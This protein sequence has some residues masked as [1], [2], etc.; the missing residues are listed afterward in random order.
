LFLS[1]QT[2]K[3]AS[4]PTPFIQV[5]DF[6]DLFPDPQTDN[7][8]DPD[9]GFEASRLRAILASAT[10]DVV[11]PRLWSLSSGMVSVEDQY[12][13]GHAYS[14]LQTK[15]QN[16]LANISTITDPFWAQLPSGSNTGTLQQFIPRINSTATWEE[17]PSL[18][19]PEDCNPSSDAFYLHYEYAVQHADLFQYTVEI[20]MPGNMSQ[21]PWKNQRSRQDITEELY[22]KMNFTG[23]TYGWSSYSG[24][25]PGVHST[26]L[27]LRT[28]T[29]YFELPNY[30]N[31]QVPGPLLDAIPS[32]GSAGELTARSLENDTTWGILNATDKLIPVGLKGPLLNIAMALFGEASFVDVQHTALAAYGDSGTFYSGCIG[33]A[34]LVSFLRTDLEES[35]LLPCVFVPYFNSLQ[36][37]YREGYDS[38]IQATVSMYFWL[39]SGP[40]AA[41][42]ER[43]E[44]AFASAAFLANDLLMTGDL[45]RGY[46]SIYTSY[47]MGADQQIPHISRAGIIVVSALL[48]LDL[49]CLLALALYS[50][51]IPRWTGTLDSFAML[52]IG[53]SM[54]EKL[55]L[56]ATYHP[57]RIRA[58]DETPG[59]IGNGSASDDGEVGTLC[60][61]GRRPLRRT[62]LYRTYGLEHLTRRRKKKKKGG[63]GA[64]YSSLEG[65]PDG[66]RVS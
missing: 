19:L 22:F 42:P 4:F 38:E 37:D 28:T 63:K 20:C 11:Q 27:T 25:L 46:G 40:D 60:L 5:S 57:E 16:T 43:V 61:G 3:H 14:P 49:A 58:L 12:N 45:Y 48:G 8:H 30:A 32:S 55:P 9:H 64:G 54:S 1:F 65:P 10:D 59:W 41:D 7:G 52:R 53:A 26:K 56:L 51:W 29:G 62:K 13:N 31:G 6:P 34:P 35:N 24:A 17:N 66:P 44:N 15:T 39:F 18:E 23:N 21:S 36:P 33:L 47:D 2:I 50:A